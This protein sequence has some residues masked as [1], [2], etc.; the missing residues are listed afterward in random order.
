M[1]T[2]L[3][4]YT[5]DSGISWTQANVTA[6]TKRL[7]IASGGRTTFFGANEQDIIHITTGNA[8]NN[9]FANVRGDNEAGIRIRGGGSYDGGT[10]ELAGGLR[11]SD[12]G[13]IKF[14]THTSWAT[15]VTACT[16][17]S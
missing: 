15:T 9:T 11:N 2:S 4:F 13:I 17:I 14:S 10:I 1:P 5:G 6:G 3:E 12:P 16:N 7:S 8:A